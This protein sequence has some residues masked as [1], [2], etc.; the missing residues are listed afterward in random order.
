[1]TELR[2]MIRISDLQKLK[3]E[4]KVMMTDQPESTTTF[5]TKKAKFKVIDYGLEG[6]F[7]LHRLYQIVY[8]LRNTN[9]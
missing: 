7:P 9:D 4:Y 2:K 3:P 5:Y 6:D 1:M 8:K